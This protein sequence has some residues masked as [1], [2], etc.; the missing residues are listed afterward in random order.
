MLSRNCDILQIF[1]RKMKCIGVCCSYLLVG[2]WVVCCC[3]LL[4]QVD[5]TDGWGKKLP[6]LGRLKWWRSNNT[7]WAVWRHEEREKISPLWRISTNPI[8]SFMLITMVTDI[9]F[10]YQNY[11][12]KSTVIFI[13]FLVFFLS[14]ISNDRHIKTKCM[15]KVSFPQCIHNV[16][17]SLSMF[18]I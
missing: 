8:H 2:W 18:Y 4:I 14:S 12:F 11:Y 17:S 1:Y 9:S 16:D 7:E 10:C 6:S 13:S 15:W 3:S 5:F